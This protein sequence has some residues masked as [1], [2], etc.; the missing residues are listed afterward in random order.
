MIG[1]GLD[2]CDVTRFERLQENEAFIRR[3]F[4]EAEI[5][6]CRKRNK[7]TPQ[8]FAARFAAKEAFVKAL[9]TG[10]RN[11][12]ALADVEVCTEESGKPFIVLHGETKKFADNYGVT[13]VHLSLSHEKG[14]AGA[15]VILE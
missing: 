8:S 13:K 15:V 9:G 4:T 3:V 1:V 2:L 14:V 11:G 6:Y 12:V 10:V 5:E 7:G